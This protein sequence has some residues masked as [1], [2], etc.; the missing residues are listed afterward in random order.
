MAHV[1]NITVRGLKDL[2]EFSARLDGGVNVLHGYNGHAKKSII[3]I[4]YSALHGDSTVLKH[5]KFSSASIDIYKGGKLYRHMI[6]REGR[7]G[8]APRAAPD[9][10]P[11]W[12]V[13]PASPSIEDCED[14]FAN[15]AYL[16][17]SRCYLIPYYKKPDSFSL[18][19]PSEETRE[20]FLQTCGSESL[21]GLWKKCDFDFMLE[22][23]SIL[24]EGLLNII[25]TIYSGKERDVDPNAGEWLSG[26]YDR[27]KM[28]LD[29]YDIG[30]N[31]VSLRTFKKML[32]ES[33]RLQR[34]A[35]Y[36]SEVVNRMALLEA[37]AAK[38]EK[39][40][41]KLLGNGRRVSF[42]NTEIIVTTKN[43]EKIPLKDL[44]LGELNA[45]LLL[46]GV[47]SVGDGIF[48]VD[49]IEY[50]IFEDLQRRLLKIMRL[51][52]SKAQIIVSTHAPVI[53]DNLEGGKGIEVS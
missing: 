39:I 23:E 4:I 16:P 19:E 41:N 6:E 24:S 10:P 7:D 21:I 30:E 31:F 42:T 28:F 49:Y 37:P 12:H 25:E 14:F 35:I 3:K 18:M 8:G 48:L 20:E 51:L 11:P 38:L 46:V 43:N 17:I 34:I 53:L 45:M 47:I 22:R 29:L 52:N 33:P 1:K 5:E 50:S 27:V 2:E 26:A 40:F 32:K 44:S 9:F 15:Y 36:A 13:E